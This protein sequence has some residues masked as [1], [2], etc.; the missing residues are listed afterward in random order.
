MGSELFESTSRDSSRWG[1]RLRAAAGA[2]V[3]VF[4]SESARTG[5]ESRCGPPVSRGA[6]ASVS[7]CARRGLR[8]HRATRREHSSSRSGQR[9]PANR[10]P[11]GGSSDRRPSR[12][13]AG[14]L[15]RLT[16]GS[17]GA[18][19]LRAARRSTTGSRRVVRSS[20]FILARPL[21][22]A[23]DTRP[24]RVGISSSAAVTGLEPG[25]TPVPG[26]RTES[27][28]LVVSSSLKSGA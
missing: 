22:A 4:Q 21:L 17:G 28:T 9:L 16:R 26:C 18:A 25:S 14:S 12:R 3:L 11:R 10:S 7:A 20:G 27:T 24:T 19:S 1:A 23:P 2:A 8:L 5:R 15:V 13:L 6:L